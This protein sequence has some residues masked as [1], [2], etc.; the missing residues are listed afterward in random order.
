[1]KKRYGSVNNWLVDLSSGSILHLITGERRRLGEYQIK[2]LNV[3]VQ[4]AGRILTR[5]ELT[6]LVWERRVIGNNSL[7]NA[8]HAL[9]AALE[10]DGKQQKIIKTIPRKGYLMEPEYCGF[11][12]REEEEI[13]AELHQYDS[14]NESE[15]Q[16]DEAPETEKTVASSAENPT[17]TILRAPAPEI[18]R[19]RYR[20][21][22]VAG[23][24]VV[25]TAFLSITLGG[26]LAKN[27][28]G[29]ALHVQ[30]TQPGVY[31]NIRLFALHH[32][33]NP[34]WLQDNPYNKLKDSFYILNQ[35]LQ[36]DSVKM[37]LFY[38]SEN[39]TLNYTFSLTNACD[40]KQLVMTVY[41][42]RIDVQR[43]NNLIVHE[44]RRKL[45]EMATCKAH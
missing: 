36:A 45:D 33:G 9:R 12:D 25:L 21:L 16:M 23:L 22:I 18:S 31:S 32:A 30:E 28:E 4:E 8:I 44:T 6:Q 38:L 43:L 26:Q 5:D 1:M 35:R 40:K 41:H 29:D 7:P 10:D 11:V 42:W 34:A 19:S 27:Y 37:N 17:T 13:D 15:N 2:L 14:E 3:L 20:P 24:L 39:Q